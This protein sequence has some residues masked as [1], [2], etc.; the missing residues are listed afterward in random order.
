MVQFTWN[1]EK[2]LCVIAGVDAKQRAIC[3]RVTQ[4]K[5]YEEEY[6]TINKGNGKPTNYKVLFAS[7]F[8]LPKNR[9]DEVILQCPVETIIEAN[10]KHS[11]LPPLS[12][13][14]EVYR[15]LYES[16]RNTPPKIKQAALSKI[17]GQIN[18]RKCLF[19][20]GDNPSNNKYSNYRV[21][22]NKNGISSVYQGGGRSSK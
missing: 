2:H 7:R 4:K 5:V 12:S 11:E 22:P 8:I 14:E 1:S 3:Y 19:L 10:K 6:I 17:A 20:L 13:L 21:V 9:F 15:R 16:M 18:A